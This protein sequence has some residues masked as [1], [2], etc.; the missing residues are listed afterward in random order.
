MIRI[1]IVV[2]VSS[3]TQT[4]R[5]LERLCFKEASFDVRLVNYVAERFFLF[6]FLQD[7]KALP[8]NACPISPFD[9][10]EE[11]PV[12][13]RIT[14]FPPNPPSKVRAIGRTQNVIAQKRNNLSIF[15][16]IA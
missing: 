1:L 12:I 14:L 6:R 2:L 7:K 5:S 9:E 15:V 3:D 8:R 10:D 11:R 16:V 13:S 4:R